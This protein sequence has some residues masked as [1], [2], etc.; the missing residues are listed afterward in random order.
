MPLTQATVD[1]AFQRYRREYDC[2]EKLAKFVANKV[3]R[4]II[5]ANTLRA[6]VTYR[7]KAPGKMKAKILKKYMNDDDVN[8]ANDAIRRVTDLTGVRVSTYLE[9]DRARVVAEIQQLFDGP[10]GDPVT[11]EVKDAEGEENY[12]RATHCQV[13]LKP[14]D[15]EE[16]NDN[17]EGLTCE[18]QVCSMLAHVWNELEHDLV[19][20][21][22]TGDLSTRERESLSI[23]GNITLS[24]DLVIKQLFDANAERV[25][26]AQDNAT[27]F[28]DVYDFV[29]RMRDD[30]PTCTQF[31]NNAGQLCE[32]LIALNVNTPALVRAQF[33]T[34]GYAD[35]SVTLLNQLIAYVQAQHDAAVTVEPLSS[36]AL[37]VLVLDSRIDDILNLH[38]MGR[39]RGRPPRI[40]SFATRFKAMKQQAAA[41]AALPQPQQPAL[42]QPAVPVVAPQ[43]AAAPEVG[44]N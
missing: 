17:L 15:L 6:S 42:A 20:K 12:Y 44:E 34:A 41:A 16:P 32:D 28:Q 3:E 1:E 8:T 5:R 43:A 31:G 7:A 27:P 26:Q 33:L 13:S 11:V 25:K 40:A 4:E 21:P 22:T 39:G 10:N 9:G 2:Y 18:I 14:E 19:Y 38:P 30:F 24:G 35:K 37:L 36:D 23:L 29:A